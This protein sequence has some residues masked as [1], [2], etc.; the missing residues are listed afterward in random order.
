M[1]YKIRSTEVRISS[2]HTNPERPVHFNPFSPLIINF[3]ATIENIPT[4]RGLMLHVSFP[5]QKSLF[6]PILERY[7]VPITP[8]CFNISV[9]LPI[10][11]SHI[12]GWTGKDSFLIIR[13]NCK[14]TYF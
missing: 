5:E 7:I 10:E 3:E 2:P 11:S 14:K 9:A 12:K 6:F 13:I 4:T 1:E 8:L